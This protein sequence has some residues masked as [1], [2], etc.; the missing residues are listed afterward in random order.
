MKV[1]FETPGAML[2]KQ[3]R[4]FRRA[5]IRATKGRGA[6]AHATG[7]RFVDGPD[8]TKAVRKRMENMEYYLRG[9]VPPCRSLS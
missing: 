7:T 4:E 8:T 5:M 1:N 2:A 3:Q 9:E 6:I